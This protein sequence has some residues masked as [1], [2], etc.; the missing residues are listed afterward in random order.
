[1][2]TKSWNA[3]HIPPEIRGLT[4]GPAV[5][6][7]LVVY[8]FPQTRSRTISFFGTSPI[9]SACCFLLPILF[10]WIALSIEGGHFVNKIIYYLVIGGISIFGEEKGWRGY[11]Q[12]Q[13]RPIGTVRGYLVLALMW[14]AW[15]FTSHLKGSWHEVV[16]RLSWLLP[17]VVAL[18][19]FLGFLTVRTSSL[20][21]AVTVHEWV[22]IV[23]DSSG[24]RTL[25][26]S[27][28]ACIPIWISLVW[29][30]PKRQSKAAEEP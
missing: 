2:N 22:D 23:A 5:A 1:V 27:A 9:R 26:W 15:H 19:F 3:S 4:W 20:L 7:F 12:D 18:T 29:T 17:F 28:I 30:W 8:F 13:L 10:A 14:E 25:F 6:A 11:L 24:D 21:L 16:V